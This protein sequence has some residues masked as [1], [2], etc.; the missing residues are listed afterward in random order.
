PKSGQRRAERKTAAGI[1][2]VGQASQNA[3]LDQA[4]RNRSA[5]TAIGHLQN[6]AKTIVEENQGGEERRRVLDSRP[7]PADGAT[8]GERSRTEAPP[9][10]LRNSIAGTGNRRTAGRKSVEARGGGKRCGG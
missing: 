6:Q 7:R 2:T 1:R 10:R 3:N 5:A 9:P 8:G 4:N